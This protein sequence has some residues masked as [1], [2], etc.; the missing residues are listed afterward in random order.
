MKSVWKLMCLLGIIALVVV[1]AFAYVALSR[2]PPTELPP[3]FVAVCVV[4]AVGCA[5]SG[6]R[7]AFIKRH[8]TATGFG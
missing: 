5:V 1:T 4:I 8:T 6:I 2:A 7:A 3:P